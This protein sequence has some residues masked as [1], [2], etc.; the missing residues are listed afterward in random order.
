MNKS[1][2][3]KK[4]SKVF[5]RDEGSVRTII[6]DIRNGHKDLPFFIDGILRFGIHRCFK[7]HPIIDKS[8]KIKRIK[9]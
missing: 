9:S 8:K 5:G 3:I 6:T 7:N 1:R 2:L 4:C